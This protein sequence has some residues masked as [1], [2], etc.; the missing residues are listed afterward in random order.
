MNVRIWVIIL[1]IHVAAI[2]ALTQT[3]DFSY[4]GHLQNGGTPANGNYDLELRLFDSLAG[5]LQVGPL[6]TRTNVAVTNG[7]LAVQADFGSVF[8]G[9]DRF[10]E[11]QVRTAGGGAYTL[12][13]PR[14][15]VNSAPYSIKSISSETATNSLQL[16]GVPANQY[17]VT[18][19]PRMTDPRPPTAESPHYIQNQITSPQPGNFFIS[20]AGSV[21]GTLVG[22]VV[23][24]ATHY[25]IGGNRILSVTGTQNIFSGFESGAAN[26]GSNNAF[27][28]WRSGRMNAGGGD[29]TF[30]GAQTG[31]ANLT[32][33]GNTFVGA[34]AGLTNT[35]GSANTFIGTSAGAN[36]QMG[37]N[38]TLIGVSTGVSAQNLVFA[39][40]IGAGSSVA[41]SNTIVLGRN[42]GTETVFIPGTI[43][44]GGNYQINGARFLSNQGTRNTFT[45]IGTGA[46]NTGTDNSFF[47]NNAG[48]ANIDGSN[49]TFFGSSTGDANTN[50][51]F[52]VFVGA[53]AGSSN[54]AG[55]SNTF[56]GTS[57]GSG[58]TAG[59]NT[60]IGRSAG[61][62][63]T[64]GTSNTTLG[65]SSNLG[66]SG[67]TF[68]TAIGAGS[69][70]T[71]SNSVWLGRSTD[72][73]YVPGFLRLAQL[74][75]SGMTALCR[76]NANTIGDCSSSLRYKT[77][78]S[79]S[80]LGL[81]LIKRLKPITFDWKD[82][83]MHDLGLGAEDVAAI[84]PL[85]VTYNS[86]GQVEGVKYDRL[87]VVLLNA[88]K[89]QQA[90]IELQNLQIKE[91]QEQNRQQ[92]LLNE[93]VIALLCS[94][95]PETEIC[96]KTQ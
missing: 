62:A 14:Q 54:S 74:G 63:N 15:R 42:F 86:K 90:Q 64:T 7:I 59:S 43:N 19:D 95:D 88:V 38:N 8:P 96:R 77:N 44:A 30:L 37:S 67:L 41:T 80:Q 45:G 39:T 3:T 51:N 55:S 12:L 13:N 60:F 84:E 31:S 82:G 56:I 66:S 78:I 24:T 85:L 35:S 89:E 2:D 22:G 52:N 72:I 27:Y 61:S 50:G 49:N 4:Q 29:N 53:N 81:D 48:L 83:G 47:G 34:G 16:D 79:N 40:A 46:A 68:A 9:P 71:E 73:V 57:A 5:G 26:T 6:V 20:G 94:K 33:L 25:S 23:N 11:I 36:H 21:Q 92:S 65:H 87:G 10:L 91:L 32:G 69:V 70:A 75:G 93:G 1:L 58:T 28:G 17:V 18:T 76:N